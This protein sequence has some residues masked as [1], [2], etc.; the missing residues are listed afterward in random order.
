[1]LDGVYHTD[2]TGDLGRITRQQKLIKLAI[3]YAMTTHR[4]PE[5]KIQHDETLEFIIPYNVDIANHRSRQL[6]PEKRG[7]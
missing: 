5:T 7:R 3:W 6:T 4:A 2:P 1:M